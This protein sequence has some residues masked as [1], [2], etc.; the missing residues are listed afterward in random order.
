M[1]LGENKE[2]G[3]GKL[4]PPTVLLP[5]ASSVRAGF[6]QPFKF[7]FQ[8][9]EPRAC[10]RGG[11]GRAFPR[12]PRRVARPRPAGRFPWVGL[13][14]RRETR[15]SRHFNRLLARSPTPQ[16]PHTAPCS[17]RSLRTCRPRAF[18]LP[19]FRGIGLRAPGLKSPWPIGLAQ[20]C[21]RP[22]PCTLRG[23]EGVALVRGWSAG[24][25]ETGGR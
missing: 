11:A 15:C 3:A 10:V 2:S 8:R 7:E 20:R 4:S 14:L 18:R 13:L 9:R 25:P 21:L 16:R 5:S 23:A 6:Q 1:S 19:P 24:P 22:P 12:P 17:N